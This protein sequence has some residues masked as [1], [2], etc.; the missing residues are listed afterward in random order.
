MGR[1]HFGHEEIISM[2]MQLLED[3]N[4]FNSYIKIGVK[5]IMD[6]NNQSLCSVPDNNHINFSQK[7]DS[8]RVQYQKSM[9]KDKMGTSATQAE[10]SCIAFDD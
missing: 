5:I 8:I 7:L 9:K 2:Y 1:Y 10:T 3:L 4:L 6:R